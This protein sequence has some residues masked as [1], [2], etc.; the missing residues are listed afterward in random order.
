MGR[1]SDLPV[2]ARVTAVLAVLKGEESLEAVARRH[3][4]S[5]QTLARWKQEFLEAGRDRL[6]G[7]GMA[8]SEREKEL[9][10]EV[11]KRDQLIGELVVANELLKKTPICR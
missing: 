10:A 6:R 3:G 4:I 1:R 8:P 11:R 2:D 7:K 5:S 9:E